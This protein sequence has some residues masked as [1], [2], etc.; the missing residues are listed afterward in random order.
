MKQ[1]DFL[2]IKM[3]QKRVSTEF[4]TIYVCMHICIYAGILRY[5]LK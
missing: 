1:I 4:V 3:E 5:E 2:S